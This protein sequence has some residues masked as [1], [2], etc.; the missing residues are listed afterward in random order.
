MTGLVLFT[1]YNDK[2][3]KVHHGS[4]EMEMW[5]NAKGFTL[6]KGFQVIGGVWASLSIS[7]LEGSLP[8]KSIIA[9]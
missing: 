8:V 3:P 6:S 4:K 1:H 7:F 5:D 9:L 2:R